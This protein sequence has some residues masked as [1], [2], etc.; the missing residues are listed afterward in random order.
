MNKNGYGSIFYGGT[1]DGGRTCFVNIALD[2]SASMSPK[3]EIVY[4]AAEK[5]LKGL[6]RKNETA[7]DSLR[8]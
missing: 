2:R 8:A 3:E 4:N 7:P 5:L 6:A 1:E